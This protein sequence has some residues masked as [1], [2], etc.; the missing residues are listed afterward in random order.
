MSMLA[1][2]KKIFSISL[3]VYSDRGWRHIA[4]KAFNLSL[5]AILFFDI[6]LAQVW[7]TEINIFAVNTVR[8]EAEFCEKAVEVPSR[9]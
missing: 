2:F 6:I 5:P 8:K 4:I 9:S 3:L 7:I 1:S